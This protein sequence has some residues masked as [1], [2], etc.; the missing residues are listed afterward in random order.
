MSDTM[1]RFPCPKCGRRLKAPRDKAGSKATC[2]TCGEK[3]LVPGT[4]V[5]AVVAAAGP[6]GSA[7][8]NGAADSDS[9]AAV[10]AFASPGARARDNDEPAASFDF[11]SPAPAAPAAALAPRPVDSFADLWLTPEPASDNAHPETANEPPPLRWSVALI[12]AVCGI[13][14]VAGLVLFLMGVIGGDEEPN[15]RDDRSSLVGGRVH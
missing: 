6:P 14:I 2:T 8:T 1:V 3:M 5:S 11:T 7:S 9:P 10:F 4:P 12:A 13:L 15:A